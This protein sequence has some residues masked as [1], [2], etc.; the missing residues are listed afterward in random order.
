MYLAMGVHWKFFLSSLDVCKLPW[1][2][3]IGRGLGQACGDGGGEDIPPGE[4]A[5]DA[6]ATCWWVS[7]ASVV[8]K[9]AA[10]SATSSALSPS[11]AGHGTEIA[12]AIK[13]ARQG[14]IRA[15]KLW[16]RSL[17]HL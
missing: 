4:A 14:L 9:W 3:T 16:A 1:G 12:G 2:R 8:D 10:S 13:C 17:P 11:F 15:I 5:V 6:L 7:R